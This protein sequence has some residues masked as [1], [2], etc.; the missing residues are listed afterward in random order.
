MK[1][2]NVIVDEELLE[3]ARR[4]AGEKTYS[5]TINKALEDMVR[6]QQFWAAYD[7]F[8]TLAHEG[9]F[10]WPGYLEE[11]RPNAIVK[12]QRM[13]AHEKRAPRKKAVRRGSR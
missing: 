8:E 2:T 1:R 5:A 10:F 4:A 6:Q 12:K 13:S 11:I 9:N 3:K 7:R